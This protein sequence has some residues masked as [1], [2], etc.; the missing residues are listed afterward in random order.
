VHRRHSAS[1]RARGGKK[2]LKQQETL[3]LKQ[4]QEHRRHRKEDSLS[5]VDDSE[6]EDAIRPSP[7]VQAG[8]GTA[9]SVGPASAASSNDSSN[10]G[11][12][13]KRKRDVEHD[14]KE[15][16]VPDEDV[17]LSSQPGQEQVA[18]PI[19]EPVTLKTLFDLTLKTLFDQ[20][21]YEE[22]EK[23]SNSL[24]DQKKYAEAEKI[25]REMLALKRQLFGAEHPG[26]LTTTRN[27]VNSLY[28]QGKDADAKEIE[29]RWLL[30]V[31][32]KQKRT[33][34]NEME[35]VSVDSDDVVIT[36]VTHVDDPVEYVNLT[37]DEAD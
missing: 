4:E 8:E 7:D 22:V 14:T 1:K 13:S 18:E 5:D 36:A 10:D 29:E 6:V 37:Q 9:P 24:S 35:P 21:K 28:G 19:G 25:D 30:P 2:F 26:T 27:L 34:A 16:I 11:A 31:L 33:S 15:E 20:E 3:K 12:G 23:L 17:E 32:W